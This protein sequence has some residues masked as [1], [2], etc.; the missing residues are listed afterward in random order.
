[1]G[2]QAEAAQPNHEEMRTY[3]Y[4]YLYPYPYPYPYPYHLGSSRPPAAS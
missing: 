1:M 2:A 4:P 3:L